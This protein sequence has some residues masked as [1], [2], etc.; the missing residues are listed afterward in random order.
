[1]KPQTNNIIFLAVG[2]ILGF[3]FFRGCGGGSKPITTGEIIK[4]DT[5]FISKFDTVTLTDLKY[6]TKTTTKEVPLIDTFTQIQLDTL[7]LSYNDTNI[8]KID[9]NNVRA[10]INVSQNKI[11]KATF[12]NE[13][14]TQIITNT[15]EQKRFQILVGAGLQYPFGAYVGAGFK[16]KK[17][18]QVQYQYSTTNT[19]SIGAFAPI[20]LKK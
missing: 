2:L 3:I 10:Q 14:E 4:S 9:T 1:M 12:I 18:L 20:R 13:K 7:Y 15:I 8:Y 19:H 5:I 17:D 11:F 16:T 6:I